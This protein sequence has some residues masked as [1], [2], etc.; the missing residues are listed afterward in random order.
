MFSSRNPFDRLAA[1]RRQ[2]STKTTP[3]GYKPAAPS[4]K[5]NPTAPP[6]GF[7]AIGSYNTI[8]RRWTA[9]IVGIPF[10]VVTSYVLYQRV[11]LGQEQKPL[12]AP[13]EGPLVAKHD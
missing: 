10:V 3:L 11:V 4:L 2:A 7:A 8:A 5:T 12:I 1:L 13:P 6:T 9:I